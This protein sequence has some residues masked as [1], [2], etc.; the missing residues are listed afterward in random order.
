M[1]LQGEGRWYKELFP[2][3]QHH[4]DAA[5]LLATDVVEDE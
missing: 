4:T 5:D 2:D 1:G 3:E